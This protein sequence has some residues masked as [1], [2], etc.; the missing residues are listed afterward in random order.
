MKRLRLPVLLVLAL[1]LSL[2]SCVSYRERRLREFNSATLVGMVYDLDQK[3]CAAAL[4]IVDGSEGPRTDINGRF[5][6][7]ALRRGDHRIRV[8]KEGF[9]PLE[10]PVSFVDRTQVLY[11][12]VV[13]FNQLLRQ[14]EEAL[15]RGKLQEA[16]GLLR[17]AETLSSDEPV[18]LYLRAV[19][20]LRLEDVEQAI[21]QLQK[22]LARGQRLPAVLLSLADIYQYRLKDAAQ[23]AAFLR[24]YLRTE[25]DPDI[26]SRLAEL[27]SQPKP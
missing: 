24:E 15:G 25:D 26:R 19:Y 13:S 1:A 21:G 4:I 5:V 9:E 18:G 2:S 7:D 8:S 14:A 10:V 23:A 17:R 3:P 12:R 6:I 20:L 22:I 27:E 11:L 16:D